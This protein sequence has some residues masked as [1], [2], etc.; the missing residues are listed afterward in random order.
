M[1]NRA[2]IMLDKAHIKH[3]TIGID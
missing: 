1:S 2:H 3:E